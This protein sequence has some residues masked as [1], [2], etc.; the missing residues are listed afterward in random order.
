MEMEI[1]LDPSESRIRHATHEHHSEL[2]QDTVYFTNVKEPMQ[3]RKISTSNLA[4]LNVMRDGDC[5]GVSI[6][7]A[8][9]YDFTNNTTNEL[10]RDIL[11]RA[12][13][14]TSLSNVVINR[15][16]FLRNV[17]ALNMSSINRTTKKLYIPLHNAATTVL[18]F[19]VE[20][21]ANMITEETFLHDLNFSDDEH[22]S[23][24]FEKMENKYLILE[25]ESSNLLFEMRANEI[26]KREH[27][28]ISH[29]HLP[30]NSFCYSIS[31]EYNEEGVVSRPGVIILGMHR[32][33]TSVLGGLVNKMGLKTGEPLIAPAED[34]LKGFFERNDVVLLNDNIMRI[35]NIDYGYRTSTFDPWKGLQDMLITGNNNDT[36]Q[37]RNDALSFLNNP[38]NFPWMLKDPRLCITIRM[39]LPLLTFVPS[40]LF[41]YRNPLDVALSMLTREDIAIENGF[42]LWYIYNRRAIQQSSD[43]CRVVTSHRSLMLQPDIEVKNI[44][45]G[46]MRCGTALPQ[47]VTKSDI[48]EF[49]DQKLHHYRTAHIDEVCANK[50]DYETLQLPSCWESID[51]F[52]LVLYRASIKAYC[53]MQSGD[54]FH[55]NYPWNEDIRD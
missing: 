42:K 53:D 18:V 39:W 46:L 41:I 24:D 14:S 27:I 40:I 34:N 6:Q 12:I 25:S 44:R 51:P 47:E 48:N 30:A 45:D 38:E 17:A 49:V 32:S 9:R 50:V 2:S 3:T 8:I 36:I 54:A 31:F 11:G 4:R 28:E 33:G 22:I 35:Q 55:T 10:S 21:G 52:H 23:T 5:R 13:Y 29:Y 7:F 20:N 16:V 43:L 1:W 19:N 26:L 15:N 37:A